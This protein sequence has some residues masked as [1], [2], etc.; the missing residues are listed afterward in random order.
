MEIAGN[1]SD[2]GQRDYEIIQQALSGNQQ[3]YAK[4]M[5][6]Y[7]NSVH[8]TIL[9]MV[10]DVNDA[11]DLTIEAFGK[12]FNR[13]EQYSPDFAFST[14]LFKIATN[15][16]I[17]FLRKKRIEVTSMDKGVMTDTGEVI[18]VEAKSKSMTPEEEIMHQQKVNLMRD[19]VTCLKP[20]YREL[21]ELRYFEELSYEEISQALDLPVGTVK[22]QLFRAREKL[23]VLME[24]RNTQ[25][26]I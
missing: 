14:W 6:L 24:K 21:V 10:R 8:H 17:D 9:K 12:A 13:L 25:D 5:S 1:L 23:A 4:L 26:N 3:A 11:E 16:C 18:Y 19:I 20:K 22:V 7:Q 15:N 2:K